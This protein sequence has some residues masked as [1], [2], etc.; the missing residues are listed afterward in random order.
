MNTGYKLRI[1][2]HWTKQPPVPPEDGP[3]DW[4]WFKYESEKEPMVLEVWPKRMWWPVGLWWSGDLHPRPS[5]PTK[6]N[7]E[8]E[9]T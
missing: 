5:K 7:T 1:K 3:S 8:K 9:S 4:H 6:R 2:D